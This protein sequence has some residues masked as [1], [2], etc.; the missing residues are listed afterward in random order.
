MQNELT[1]FRGPA[2]RWLPL[3]VGLTGNALADS[4]SPDAERDYPTNVY[5][6]DTHVHTSYSTGDAN[7]LGG[8]D[9]TPETAY[10]FALGERVTAKNGM[11][12]RIRKPLD[13]LVI[14]DHAEGLGLAYEMQQA[15]AELAATDNGRRRIEAWQALQASSSEDTVRAFRAAMRLPIDPQYHRTIWQRVVERADAFNEPGAFTTFAG[16]EW[17]SL[18]AAMGVFGNLHRVVVFRDGADKTGTITPFSATHSRN[19]E[20]LW[21]FLADYKATTGGDVLAI[22]HNPNLSNGEMFARHT[23]DGG[24]A[25]SQW[26]ALRQVIEPLVEATQQKGDSEAHPVLSP[27]DEFADF[28]TWHSWAGYTRDPGDHICCAA[29]KDPGFDEQAFRRQKQADYVRPALK[30]G[31]DL[32]AALG[33]NPFKFGVIGSTDTHVSFPS[34]DND[35]YWAQ[36]PN[37]PPSA[38]RPTDRFSP[39][40]QRPLHWETAASGYAAVWA[41]ENTRDSIFAAMRRREVYATT[42]PRITVR[43]FAGWNFAADDAAA[44]NVSRIGYAKGVPMGGD[45]AHGPAGASPTFLVAAVR[46]PDG[47]NLDRIQIIKGWRT[48]DG[49]LHE[50]VHDVAL[51]DDREVGADDAPA[52]GSTVNVANASYTNEIGD[53]ELAAVWRDPAFD[54]ADYAFYYVRVLEI[55]T[56]RWPAYDAKY[57][58]AGKL[59][60]EVR[61]VTQERA[62]T[63]A[64]WYTP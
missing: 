29:R 40:W 59:P 3:L 35:N 7:F 39:S 41:H 28:E 56:P 52:V 45:L 13:F 25:T 19:P 54:P 47:A 2:R 33:V 27:T 36:Y 37:T 16:Y 5:W 53:P 62:Y 15:D 14:A 9:V 8:N 63:S 60:D 61:V 18:G 26:A 17:S 43:V 42:G 24:E 11:V 50:K 1:P 22:P 44:P 30:T 51:S 48:S 12:A 4:Y 34:A 31:L 32:A 64:I 57:F 38:T 21:A 6:G 49:A 55:P 23:F 46:D 10:R 20:D 58:G